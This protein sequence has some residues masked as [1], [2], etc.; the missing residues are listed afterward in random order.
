MLF[1]R[2]LPVALVTILAASPPASAQRRQL[3]AHTHGEGRLA[4]AI[5]GSKVQLELEAPASDI[6]GFE[7]APSTAAQRKAL[8]T[9]KDRLAKGSTL[10]VLTPAAGCKLVSAEVVAVGA[11]AASAKGKDDDHD[12]GHAK[13]SKPKADAPGEKTHE[14]GAHS[15]FRATYAFECAAVEKL[16]GIAFEYFKAFKAADRL[17]VTAIGAKGQ[18]SFVVTRKKPAID[19]GGVS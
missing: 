19:L 5:D 6:V 2:V 11:L 14:H 9:A 4:I 7:H 13:D 17:D 15:E 3:D 18:S 8:A 1:S 12:H 10:F 16:A